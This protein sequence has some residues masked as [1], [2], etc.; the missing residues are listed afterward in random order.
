MRRTTAALATIAV[1]AIANPAHAEAPSHASER[2]ATRLGRWFVHAQF[3]AAVVS[4]VGSS[5]TQPSRWF[6]PAD[7][8][9]L[10][11]LVGIGYWLLPHLRLTLTMQFNETV[12]GL[13]A[14]ASPFTFMGVIAWAAYTNGPFFAGIG[15]VIAPRSFGMWDADAGI[16]ANAGSGVPLGAGFTL[17]IGVQ[18]PLMLARRVSWSVS[19][20]LY[21]S[22]RF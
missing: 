6:S 18:M 20:Y 9:V 7:R 15:G 2:A 19:P 14:N 4:F 8:V 17:G 22:K 16:F 5:G 21:L 3:G 13:P 11:Q 1:L 10:G 12:S